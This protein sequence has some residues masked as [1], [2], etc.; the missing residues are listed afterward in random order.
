MFILGIETTG[1]FC[2]VVIIGNESAWTAETNN[3]LNHLQDLAP[4]IDDV[5][6]KANC[7]LDEL[8]A[9]AVSTGP[10]SFTGIR[11]GVSTARAISQIKNI[12]CISVDSLKALSQR[13]ISKEQLEMLVDKYF[14]KGVSKKDISDKIIVATMIDARQEQIYCNAFY[15]GD[16]IL[17]TAPRY[18]DDFLGCIEAFCKREEVKGIIIHGDGFKK[19][20]ESTKIYLN[21]KGI[22][23][24]F[25]EENQRALEVAI[26]GKVSYLSDET[27]TFR[28]L[29]PNYMR[30]PEAQRRLEERLNN[31]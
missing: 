21:E 16:E 7:K 31:S 23:T 20:G 5:L 25:T 15:Q 30:K 6:K 9:I 1:P 24:G 10:G 11:I 2:S 27:L 3:N 26:Q 18:L 29:L 28:Q 14:D 4:L 12:P 8:S 17:K 19:Y 13:D 22:M